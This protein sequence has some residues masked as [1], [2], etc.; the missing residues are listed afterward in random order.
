MKGRMGRPPTH[1]VPLLNDIKSIKTLW[2]T[3]GMS[4]SEMADYY[5]LSVDQMRRY[6]S[7]YLQSRDT[8]S[9]IDNTSI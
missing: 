2:E 8:K 9:T 3:E 6:F 4:I 7:K 1:T 5:D